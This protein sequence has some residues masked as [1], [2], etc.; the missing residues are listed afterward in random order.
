[1]KLPPGFRKEKC[2]LCSGKLGNDYA[3]IKYTYEE[4]GESKDG[5]QKICTSCVADMEKEPEHGESI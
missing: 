4:N 5:E 3:V 1:M 2:F